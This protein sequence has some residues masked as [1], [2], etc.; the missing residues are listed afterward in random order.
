MTL[1]PLFKSRLD[2][3]QTPGQGLVVVTLLNA[4]RCTSP[5]GRTMTFSISHHIKGLTL[6]VI[7]VI[8]NG[9][10]IGSY[11]GSI[12]TAQDLSDFDQPDSSG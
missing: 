2:A 6:I 10:M 8:L 4:H 7:S 11:T 3:S 12:L 1:Y 5:G 9:W